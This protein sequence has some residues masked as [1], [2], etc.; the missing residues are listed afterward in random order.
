[1]TRALIAARLS[2]NAAEESSRI[3]RDDEAAS[4]WAVGAGLEVVATSEDRNVSGSVSPFKRAG[5]GPWL[6]DASLLAKYD[7]LVASSVDRLGRSAADLFRLREWAE[8]NG[9]SIRILSPPLSWPPAPDDIAGPIVWDV[10]ARVAEL[11]LRMITQ[12]YAATRAVVKENG[13][14]AGKPPWGFQV[15]GERYNKRLQVRADLAPALR[16]MVDRA[17]RGDT[18][19]SIAE[20]LDDSG[21]S[22]VHG[23]PWSQTSVRIVLSSPA[24]KGRYESEDGA[25]LH[26]FD[27]LMSAGE[28][29]ALQS[30]L[31]RRPRR[32]GAITAESAML[33]GVIFCEHCGAPMYRTKSKQRHKDG[34]VRVWFYYRCNGTDRRASTCKN[35]VPLE[36]ADAWVNTMFTEGPW[37]DMELVE[38]QSVPGEDHAEEIADIEEEI[39]SLDFDSPDFGV[40]QRD[41]LAQRARLRELPATPAEVVEVPTGRT[42]SD[43]WAGLAEAARR[44]YLAAADV[45]VLVSVLGRSSAPG[46]GLDALPAPESNSLSDLPVRLL[47][48]DFDTGRHGISLVG[49]PNRLTGSLR[50]IQG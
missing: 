43:V 45:R 27:G 24:L 8:E 50:H 17:L 23:G 47:N 38:I 25:V 26:K 16:E 2:R 14:F 36:E 33:T 22:T 34:T 20:W 13:A 39:R 5:L 48:L 40:R 15:V 37:A 29:K 19:T 49:Y 10:L 30:A 7:V 44:N 46:A 35:M 3:D 32:R 18:Y 28:W 1:M 31:D 41:L 42:V 21:V 6:T 11:E 4:A 9:K 12:R